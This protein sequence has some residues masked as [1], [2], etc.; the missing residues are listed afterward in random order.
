MLSAL[1]LAEMQ[2]RVGRCDVLLVG[3]RRCYCRLGWRGPLDT[4]GGVKVAIGMCAW[5]DTRVEVAEGIARTE[6]GLQ[7]PT[8]APMPRTSGMRREPNH[9]CIVICI[10]YTIMYYYTYIY[11]YIIYIIYI[12]IYI[13]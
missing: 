2:P 9:I 1:L 5:V 13:L 10:I 4:P 7:P 11:I 3:G 6:E 8:S 12:Y